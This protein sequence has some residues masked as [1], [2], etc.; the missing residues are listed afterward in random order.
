MPISR[1]TTGLCGYSDRLLLPYVDVMF[2][3]DLLRHFVYFQQLYTIR[4]IRRGSQ[5]EGLTVF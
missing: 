2:V 5:S 4:E 1:S 3:E